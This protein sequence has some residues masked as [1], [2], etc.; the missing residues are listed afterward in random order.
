M[1]ARRVSIAMSV[2][3]VIVLMVSA[4]S[5]AAAPTPAPALMRQEAGSG[6]APAQ[7]VAAPAPPA[8]DAVSANS[9]GATTSIKNPSG[10]SPYQA[11]RMIIKNGEM[12]LMVA[13]T[14]RA[15]DQVTSAAVD[16][17]GYIVSGRTWVQ[18]GYKYATINMG[19]PSDQFEA[20]QRQL[21]TLAIEVLND[22]ASGQ[23]VSDEYVDLQSRLTNLEATRARIRE[24]LDKATKVEEAL[25]VN[26]QLTEIEGEIEQVKGRMQ[27]LKDRA[28]YSTI[29]VNIEQQRPTPTPYPTPTPTYWQ[30]GETLSDAGDALGDILRNLGDLAIWL[31]VVVAPLAVP[32]VGVVLVARRARRKK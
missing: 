13:N 12:S 14:D 30:P 10:A 3:V 31:V 32:V 4:C 28:A 15:I 6:S 16:S 8:A 24:F 21:R 19:V 29:L 26:A 11:N 25:Q 23:D 7:P 22:T 18:D 5:P 17:G 2:L 1:N 9:S 27:Y 20:V